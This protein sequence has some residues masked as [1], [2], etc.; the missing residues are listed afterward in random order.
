MKILEEKMKK[1]TYENGTSSKSQYIYIK[2]DEKVLASLFYR[3]NNYSFIKNIVN[4][5]L[6]FK[7][8]EPFIRSYFR[9]TG[10]DWHDTYIHHP[11]KDAY[12]YIDLPKNA[13]TKLMD[14][15]TN[16]K[17]NVLLAKYI[18]IIKK[19]ADKYFA[20]CEKCDKANE[21][22]EYNKKFVFTMDK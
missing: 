11:T 2:D 13:I 17:F 14:C 16:E 8:H 21:K 9:D 1:I 3:E 18:N 15:E 6:E 12:I 22:K 4:H 10:K 5:F 19:V 20:L 7:K